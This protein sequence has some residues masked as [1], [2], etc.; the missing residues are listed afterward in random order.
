[1]ARRWL[2]IFPPTK[3]L[4]SAMNPFVQDLH[5][6]TQAD[7]VIYQND[8]TRSQRPGQTK[9]SLSQDNYDPEFADVTYLYNFRFR[10]AS[11]TIIEQILRVSGRA[12][13][14]D[15]S[16][17][18]DFRT[19]TGTTALVRDD[20]HSMETFSNRLIMCSGGTVPQTWTGS[21][22]MSDLGGSPPNGRMTRKHM[23]RLWIAGVKATPHT[24]YF[25]KAFDATIW[26][27]RGT[28]SLEID[29][30]DNDPIGITAI[31]PSFRGELYV[32]KRDAIYQVTGNSPFNFQVLPLIRNHGCIDH[33]AVAAVQNDI[34]YA[35][36]RGIH[37]LVASSKGV[38]LDTEL[39]SF[40]INDKWLT[41][42]NTRENLKFK[43]IYS[44][45]LDSILFLYPK[46]SSSM[47]TELLGFSLPL[48]LPLI[49]VASW[50][51][52]SE[53]SV[54]YLLGVVMEL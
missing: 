18:G 22:V 32:A 19:I 29:A 42:V 1:M 15:V 28:G 47:T 24:L 7:N 2:N 27:G 13:D 12:V 50:I 45:L 40:P 11:N 8:L 4:N 49:A 43:M 38:G 6:L 5:S 44:K 33:N 20:I 3:G 39:A 21:G 25:S 23:G 37:S 41:E 34:V 17:E 35:S 51:L 48:R 14:Q 10:N 31:F 26:S 46:G 36:D 9:Y 54:V 53:A 16:R 30:D 52:Q